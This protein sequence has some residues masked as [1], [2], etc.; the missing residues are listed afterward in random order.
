M[1]ILIVVVQNK[2]KSE[3]KK[4]EETAI[5]IANAKEMWTL[6]LAWQALEFYIKS[7]ESM[8]FD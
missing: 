2:K 5:V 1:P 3:R 6:L 8:V 4:R 7:P